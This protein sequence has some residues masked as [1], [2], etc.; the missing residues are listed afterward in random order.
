MSDL[1]K[2]PSIEKSAADRWAEW[3][4]LFSNDLPEGIRACG[5]LIR[6]LIIVGFALAV[7][8]FSLGPLIQNTRSLVEALRFVGWPQVTVIISFVWGGVA[9]IAS[10]SACVYRYVNTR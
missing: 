5:L 10:I 3:K 4:K 7:L 1:E 6:L 2:K 8:R 9:I